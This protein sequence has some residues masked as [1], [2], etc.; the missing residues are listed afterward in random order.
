MTGAGMPYVVVGQPPD[1]NY[2]VLHSVNDFSFGAGWA[3]VAQSG[4]V[5]SQYVTSHT[6]AAAL[7]GYFA[8]Y[9]SGTALV[10]P[11]SWAGPHRLF[12]IAR[13]SNG[14]ATLATPSAPT[15]SQP[16]PDV[17]EHR[18]AGRRLAAL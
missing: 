9:A 15:S 12:V 8:T 17:G 6:N 14:W 5:A 7:Q 1:P 10:P 16:N 18:A 2:R 13:A 11:L 4:A 3:Q